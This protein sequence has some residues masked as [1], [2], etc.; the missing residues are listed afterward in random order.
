MVWFPTTTSSRNRSAQTHCHLLEHGEPQLSHPS[1]K[2]LCRARGAELSGAIPP[3][4]TQLKCC[5]CHTVLGKTGA[6]LRCANPQV[7]NGLHEKVDSCNSHSCWH[8]PKKVPVVHPP[9]PSGS[10]TS[11][12]GVN[13]FLFPAFPCEMVPNPCSATGKGVICSAIILSLE[14]YRKFPVV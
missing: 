3:Q 1:E 7:T 2:S 9:L 6:S 8:D 12:A 5:R 11:L 4:H 13:L 14:K 10:V